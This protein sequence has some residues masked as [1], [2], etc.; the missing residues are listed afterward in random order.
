MREHVTG[1][2]NV[3]IGDVIPTPQALQSLLRFVYN[4]DVAM[5]PEDSLYLF[6][7]PVFFGFSTSRLQ[8]ACKRN[9]EVNVSTKN[10]FGILE[11][12]HGIG[13]DEMKHRALQ[14]I[15][16]NFAKVAS[17]FF[18]VVCTQSPQ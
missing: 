11:A 3:S 1:R 16:N 12:A 6:S 9:L 13:A 4:G 7:A 10:V 17:G 5:P 8:A 18:C 15:V 2:I 14:I